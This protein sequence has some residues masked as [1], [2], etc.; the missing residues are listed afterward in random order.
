[1]Q[2]YIGFSMLIISLFVIDGITMIKEELS[3][4]MTTSTTMTSTAKGYSNIRKIDFYDF[5]MF[6]ITD[7]YDV[8]KTTSKLL[9]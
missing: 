5:I 6:S 2:Y 3:S 8:D 4:A 9:F 1:M 7:I